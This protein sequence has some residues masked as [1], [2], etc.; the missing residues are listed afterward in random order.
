MGEGE[1]AGADIPRAEMNCTAKSSAQPFLV[2]DAQR[3]QVLSGHFIPPLPTVPPMT[4]VSSFLDTFIAMD[5]KMQDK[6]PFAL[7][8]VL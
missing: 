1:G 5:T 3:V 7:C 4:S 6:F 8:A 2:N